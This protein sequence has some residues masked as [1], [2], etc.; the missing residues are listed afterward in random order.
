MSEGRGA[1]SLRKYRDT[2]QKI[3][4]GD[5]TVMTAD[6]FVEY[7]GTHGLSAAAKEVD[8]VTTGTFGAMC[9]SGAFLNFGHAE[10]PIKMVRCWLND[11]PAY[12][13]LAAVDAYIGTT[14]IS[15]RLGI[16]YGGGYVIEDLVSHKEIDLRGEG[17]VTDCYPRAYIETSITMRRPTAQNGYCI[18]TW[19]RFYPISVT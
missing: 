10:P 12:K 5:A 19:V 1:E 9:S 17:Y 18:P 14:A 15:E 13:G 6:E 2:N 8:V 3:E 16:D 11:V 4:S 7:A